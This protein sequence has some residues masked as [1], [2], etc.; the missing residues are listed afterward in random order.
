MEFTINK[1]IAILEKTPGVIEK[2]LSNLP[3]DWI[4]LNEGGETWSPYDI[5]GHLVH[6]ERS[7]WIQRLEIILSKNE[8]KKFIPFNRFAQFTESKGKTI[9]NLLDDFKVLR[10][11]NIKTL[12]S[13]KISEEFFSLTGIHPV[14]GTVTL[15]NLIATWVVHDLDHIAQLSRVMA[16]QYKENVGPWKEYLRILKDTK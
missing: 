11:D 14:F 6:G 7:D 16:F 2:M 13:K 3:D 9:F 12:K 1:S 8:D 10:T 15:Q 4:I 5:V